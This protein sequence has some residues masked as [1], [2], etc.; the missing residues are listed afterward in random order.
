MIG[1]LLIRVSEVDEG[2]PDKTGFL[3]GTCRSKTQLCNAA[4]LLKDVVALERPESTI[5]NRWGRQ[6]HIN[7]RTHV[8]NEQF[9]YFYTLLTQ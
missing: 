1:Q 4:H 7:E 3:V 6:L 8:E 5:I 2:Q 9:P